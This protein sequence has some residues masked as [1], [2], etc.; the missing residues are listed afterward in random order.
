MEAVE[1]HGVASVGLSE[2]FSERVGA[3]RDGDHVN[4][5]RHQAIAEDREV[6]KLALLAEGLQIEATVVV[7][8]EDVLAVVA[9][10]RGV[11]RNGL[12]NHARLSRHL[13]RLA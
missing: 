3:T 9:P 10:L 8:E 5:I 12:R 1:A 4:V 7:A 6:E 13:V 11:T 2:G